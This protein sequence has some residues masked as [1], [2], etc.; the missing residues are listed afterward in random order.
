MQAILL[1]ELNLAEQ[2]LA[3]YL[4]Q[5]RYRAGRRA[6][7]E[8][9][10]IGPQSSYETDLQGIAAEIAV[11]KTL[12]VYPDLEVGHTPDADLMTRDGRQLDVKA[13]K[14]STGHLLAAPWKDKGGAVDEY[15]LVVGKFPRYRIAGV[16]SRDELLRDERLKDLGHG[17]GYAATQAELHMLK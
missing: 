4:A 11:A 13:T 3:Q 10:Q 1:I 5:Q 15:V 6:G 7:I 2:K 14:Y 16:M 8:D 17:R 12:N 9:R